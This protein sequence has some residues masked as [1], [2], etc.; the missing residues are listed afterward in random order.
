MTPSFYITWNLVTIPVK[1]EPAA[2]GKKVELT[3]LHRPCGAKLRM[4]DEAKLCTSC[5]KPVP[6]DQIVKGYEV[7]KG[8][9]VQIGPDEIAS[10]DAEKSKAMEVLGFVPWSDIDP[11]YLGPSGY[12]QAVDKITAKLYHAFRQAMEAEGVCAVVKHQARGRDVLAVV[13]AIRPAGLM[14]HE[15]FYQEEVRA[16]QP[17]VPEVAPSK[18]ELALAR[19]LV[20][21]D[22][23]AWQPAQY[24]NEYQGRLEELIRA[25]M[26]GAPMAAPAPR[27]A[28]PVVDLMAALQ[29]SLKAKGQA[30]AKVAAA[31]AVKRRRT[32]A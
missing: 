25:R 19:Q 20:R 15:A 11:V 30:G 8:R 17:E 28:A 10:L 7:T 16:F 3:N 1:A 32:A 29:Q 26:E 21:Q 27:A 24:R 18:D 13:R 9:W 23:M 5:S 4:S 22:A 12:M 14:L 6:A 31:K 2:R